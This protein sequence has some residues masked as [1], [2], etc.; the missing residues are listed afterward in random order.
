MYS[1]ASHAFIRFKTIHIFFYLIEIT[2]Q[3]MDSQCR[4]AALWHAFSTAI[5]ITTIDAF[6]PLGGPAGR[7]AGRPSQRPTSSL[8]LSNVRLVSKDKLPYNQTPL[9]SQPG[10]RNPDR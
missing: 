7:P 6:R 10:P 4:Q 8:P 1:L 2:G 5:T 3:M 9:L